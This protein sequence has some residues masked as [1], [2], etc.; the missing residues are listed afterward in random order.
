[1]IGLDE[2]K[3]E[4]DH[5]PF[6]WNMRQAVRQLWPSSTARGSK[7]ERNCAGF[8]PLYLPRYFTWHLST[9]KTTPWLERWTKRLTATSG[10]LVMTTTLSARPKTNTIT[11]ALS[12]QKAKAP[13]LNLAEFGAQPKAL[14]SR[15][16]APPTAPSVQPVQPV[17]PVA[18]GPRPKLK[19]YRRWFR[20]REKSV[21]IAAMIWADLQVELEEEVSLSSVMQRIQ[22]RFCEALG[23]DA[24]IHIESEDCE[25][26]LSK[27]V[28]VCL[29]CN[30]EDCTAQWDNWRPMQLE[31]AKIIWKDTIDAGSSRL[32]SRLRPCWNPK[33][34]QIDAMTLHF[35]A[36]WIMSNQ[37]STKANKC[38]EGS[39]WHE[40]ARIFGEVN[41]VYLVHASQSEVAYLVVHYLDEK[42][43]QTAYQ[44]LSGRCLYNPMGPS[45][46]STTDLVAIRASYG[47]FS[48]L[49][50]QAL[51]EVHQHLVLWTSH[52][53]PL[54]PPIQSPPRGLVLGPVFELCPLKGTKDQLTGRWT[55][56][57]PAAA[58]RLRIAPWGPKKLVIGK[59]R[60]C[61]LC[62]TYEKAGVSAKH[63]VLWLET[64]DGT[65]LFI[66][67][68]S[69]NGTWVNEKRLS[70]ETSEELK[71]G[72]I[73]RI[74]DLPQ[75]LVRRFPSL[76]ICQNE[77]RRLTEIPAF[78]VPPCPSFI[79][80]KPDRDRAPPTHTTNPWSGEIPR[81]PEE[82]TEEM[83]ETRSNSSKRRRLWNLEKKKRR[84]AWTSEMNLHPK[85][86]WV[87]CFFFNEHLLPNLERRRCRGQGKGLGR[88]FWGD[89]GQMDFPVFWLRDFSD[90]SKTWFRCDV[91]I[92]CALC[93]QI[94]FD[95]RRDAY[96]SWISTP[97]L[98]M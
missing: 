66:S 10:T 9:Q 61:N 52:A 79:R 69:K 74:A 47:T 48:K 13:G 22:E 67:D 14:G 63:A 81:I 37:S 70:K 17:Q 56:Q 87:G 19:Q 26:D 18:P 89:F 36:R 42:G 16:K 43:P 12:S 1:M 84:G 39:H 94:L 28:F 30:A 53:L 11:L 72:D 45:V 31:G 92:W 68:T 50:S 20:W 86:I 33:N 88:H 35:P 34:L 57:C 77:G 55:L 8:T 46:P 38:P 49:M 60:S 32:P 82:P 4:D 83:E 44:K 51:R 64:H 73:L 40:F 91:K 71:D 76:D 96:E 97:K 65:G 58:E 80:V 24:V 98:V 59:Y 15:P 23:K 41:E 27:R 25:S 29:R 2:S 3:R 6:P 5:L 7:V 93:N 95:D 90:R 78:R 21:E 85:K 54:S 75:Y 62:I